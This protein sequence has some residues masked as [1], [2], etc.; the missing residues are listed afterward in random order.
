MNSNR[1]ICFQLHRADAC[2]AVFSGFWTLP[3][4]LPESAGFGRWLSFW[5]CRLFFPDLVSRNARSSGQIQSLSAEKLGI[6][7]LFLVEFVLSIPFFKVRVGAWRVWRGVWIIKIR[8]LKH[9]LKIIRNHL[10]MK[11]LM[12]A[13]PCLC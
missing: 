4:P 12:Q 13:I 10:R 11:F 5:F 8:L 9:L 3:L 6:A 2:I 7:V 1:T